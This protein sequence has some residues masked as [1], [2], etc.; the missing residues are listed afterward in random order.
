[1]T[2][3]EGEKFCGLWELSAVDRPTR[4]EFRDYF[5]DEDLK[6]VESMPGSSCVYR[7][8]ATE[9]GTRATCESVFDSVEGLRTVLEVGVIEGSTGAIT[10]IDDLLARD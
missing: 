7:F 3:P 4:L 10:Q 6:V 8:E 2:S 9:T 5:A 1:M